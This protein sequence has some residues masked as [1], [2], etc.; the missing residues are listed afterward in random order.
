LIKKDEM[1][2]AGVNRRPKRGWLATVRFPVFETAANADGLGRLRLFTPMGGAPAELPARSFIGF[3]MGQ[4]RKPH[5]N[6]DADGGA[7]AGHGTFLST[8]HCNIV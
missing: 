2:P 4:I 6:T 7:E 8:R 5:I 3:A 1:K